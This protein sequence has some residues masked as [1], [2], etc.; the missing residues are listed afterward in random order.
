MIELLS[1][2]QKKLNMIN[3]LYFNVISKVRTLFAIVSR[4]LYFNN[5]SFE[6]KFLK[7]LKNK[8]F[9]SISSFIKEIENRD[10]IFDLFR[11]IAVI[12]TNDGEFFQN[13]FKI[14]I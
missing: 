11:V 12:L 2:L 9:K 10:V 7:N 14:Y 5:V 3:S 13:L 8:T 1:T 6:I 4:N